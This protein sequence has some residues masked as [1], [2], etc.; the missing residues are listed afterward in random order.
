M[1][2]WTRDPVGS[3]TGVVA[4]DR[5]QEPVQFFATHL[6][7]AD[8][9]RKQPWTNCFAGLHRDN[10]GPTISML[11]KMMTTLHPRHAETSFR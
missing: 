4:L 7:I 2:M 8:D 5:S 3:G 1:R 10:C 11:K 9:F 6:T